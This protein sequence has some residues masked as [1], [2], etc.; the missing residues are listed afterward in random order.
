VKQAEDG[1]L[2]LAATDLANHLS[3]AHLTQR[4]RAHAEGRAQVPHRHDPA[5][6]RLRARGDAHERK[7]LDDLRERGIDVVDGGDAVAAMRRGAGAIAQPVLTVG[8]W[9]GRLDVL[10]RVERESALGRWS[11]EVV[12]TKL[13][14]TTGVRPLRP[15]SP[16]VPPHHR[17]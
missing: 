14:R 1:A 10:L 15:L 13:A 12:D 11:Y 7:Y 6:D 5:L 3:C 17:P 2:R 4:E 16:R 9:H 8:R